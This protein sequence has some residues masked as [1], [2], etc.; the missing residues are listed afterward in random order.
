MDTQVYKLAMSV[1]KKE[2]ITT[3]PLNLRHSR[4]AGLEFCGVETPCLGVRLS[5]LEVT[6]VI[7]AVAVAVAV[8]VYR[9]V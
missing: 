6:N 3:F 1:M 4:P 7:V 9:Y 5:L 8:Y 2:S